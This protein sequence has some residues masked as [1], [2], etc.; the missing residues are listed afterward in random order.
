[1]V[2][3]H[4]IKHITLRHL[5]LNKLRTALTVIGIVLGVAVFVSLQVAIH[6]AIESFNSTVDHVTGKA[7]LQVTSSGRGFPEETYLKIKK[8]PGIKAATPVIQDIARSMISTVSPSTFLALMSS[9]INRS[10]T[11]NLMNPKKKTFNF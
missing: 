5:H 3:Y 2:F 10:G 9:A 6:T 11:I 4:L 1:M 7:N 8:V